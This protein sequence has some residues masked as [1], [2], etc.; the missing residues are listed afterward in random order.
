[1]LIGFPIITSMFILAEIERYNRTPIDRFEADTRNGANLAFSTKESFL[2]YLAIARELLLN[3]AYFAGKW[4]ERSL[5][6]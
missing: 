4:Q 3:S 1:M 5:T 2:S 6:E